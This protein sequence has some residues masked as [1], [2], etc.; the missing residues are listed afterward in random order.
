MAQSARATALRDVA[1]PTFHVV[2][3]VFIGAELVQDEVCDMRQQTDVDLVRHG[4]GAVSSG[5]KGM[6]RALTTRRLSVGCS[7]ACKT[8]Q[9]ES[10][11]VHPP[12]ALCARGGTERAARGQQA[13]GVQRAAGPRAG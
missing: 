7:S 4:C 11:H 9:L 12:G 8:T 10:S 1:H 3:E 2:R 13:G 6:S 5:S